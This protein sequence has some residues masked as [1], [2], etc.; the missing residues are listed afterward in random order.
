MFSPK[1]PL[2][3]CEQSSIP[4]VNDNLLNDLNKNTFDFTNDV[5]PPPKQPLVSSQL[6]SAPQINDV[7]LTQQKNNDDKHQNENLNLQQQLRHTINKDNGESEQSFVYKKFHSLSLANT[8]WSM[9]Q[10]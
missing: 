7:S 2:I 3:P 1:Q 6:S 10:R 4:Q 9:L 5:T 8:P